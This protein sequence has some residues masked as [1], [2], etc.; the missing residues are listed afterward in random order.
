M[1]RRLLCKIGL[2]E[3]ENMPHMDARYFRCVHCGHPY[4]IN[5]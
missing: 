4:A 5:G 1:L 3:L 2:H